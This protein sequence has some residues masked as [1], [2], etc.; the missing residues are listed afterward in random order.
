M[1]LLARAEQIGVV[2]RGDFVLSSGLTSKYYI[3]G[4]LLSLD[5]IGAALL[6][7]IIAQRLPVGV[8]SVG[9]PAVGAVPLVVATVIAAEASR[10]LGGFYMRSSVKE[11]GRQQ[12]IEGSLV[13]PAAILEDTCTT[14][15]SALKAA[16]ELQSKG[17]EVSAVIAVFDRG[18]AS[19]IRERGYA[20]S[21]ILSATDGKLSVC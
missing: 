2:K 15:A 4:R 17:V 5:G 10:D 16:E 13:S 6:G 19:F 8:Q 11:H 14:G 20:Y 3:D 1:Q 18:G 7:R 9:G 21:A 12:L